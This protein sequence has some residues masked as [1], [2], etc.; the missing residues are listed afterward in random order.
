MKKEIS[1]FKCNSFNLNYFG[2]CPSASNPGD[3]ASV[4]VLCYLIKGEK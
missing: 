2:D 1:K 3:G 4:A